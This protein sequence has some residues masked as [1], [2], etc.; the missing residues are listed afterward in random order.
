MMT[1]MRLSFA[2]VVAAAC[3]GSP[4]AVEPAQP[5]ADPAPCADVAAHELTVMNL[6]FLGERRTSEMKL[7]IQA[8]CHN[9]AWPVATRRCVV[10]ATS[11]DEMSAC[12]DRLTATQ[13]TAFERDLAGSDEVAVPEQ[14]PSAPPPPELLK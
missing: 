7:K 14:P 11:F 13:R 9:D 10:T 12:H 1:P 4:S 5:A 2:L 3:G 6:G 8:H